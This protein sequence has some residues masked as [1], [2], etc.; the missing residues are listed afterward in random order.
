MVRREGG[1]AGPSGGPGAQLGDHPGRRLAGAE[2]AL[3][4]AAQRGPGVGAGPGPGRA[5]GQGGPVGLER[6]RAC[7][8]QAARR[9]P[10][11]QQAGA[12]VAPGP[13]GLE[14]GAAVGGA[15]P[16][17]DPAA[18][19]QLG[20]PALARAHA[21][22]AGRGLS[23]PRSLVEALGHG[24]SLPGPGAPISAQAGRPCTRA[25]AGRQP[26]W[27]RGH[28]PI[29]TSGAAAPAYSRM[30]LRRTMVRADTPSGP[31]SRTPTPGAR[32]AGGRRSRNR[33]Y[34][35]ARRPDHEYPGS[36]SGTKTAPGE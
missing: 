33:R 7:R 23:Q 17:R 11:P 21:D 8:G 30:G 27:P 9:R 14:G 31:N 3:G 29:G 34:P 20:P 6:A 36:S 28:R 26:N 32:A 4:L 35:R 13:P 1:R 2:A 22:Q 19:V 18:Q 10:G 24:S 15:E 16:H 5:R 25:R 12:E